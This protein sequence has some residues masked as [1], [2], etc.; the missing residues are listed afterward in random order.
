MEKQEYRIMF[1][2][3]NTFWWYRG[4]HALVLKTIEKHIPSANTFTLL[5]AGCGTGRLLEL[6]NKKFK[7]NAECQGIDF[8]DE[9]LSF[10]AER[11]VENTAK[12]SVCELPFNDNS[13]DFVTSLDVIY[14]R[15]VED[16]I[17]ALKEFKRVLKPGGKLI[18]NLPA[19]EFMTSRHD[20]A[21]HTA[22]RYN[23]SILAKKL[24]QAKLKAS[25]ISYRNSILF[26]LAF[27]VRMLQKFLKNDSED[28]KK[29][30]LSEMPKTINII[31]EKILLL[32]NTIINNY[33]SL[34]F[35][36]SIF[37]IAEKE[38]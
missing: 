11:N 19:Y 3:E 18:I 30:D 35:G 36:L 26:P 21:V 10:C 29:S 23:R 13:F 28:Q 7:N 12:A 24:S 1:A 6:I 16:D 5:D 8:S 15:G 38:K 31:F 20:R 32:E 27:T 25:K 22:R 37:G 9:A 4:L 2:K 34:P 14:H 17:T 33:F